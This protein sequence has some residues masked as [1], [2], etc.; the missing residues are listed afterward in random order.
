MRF[1][2]VKLVH[3]YDRSDR[4]SKNSDFTKRSDFYMIDNLSV[5]FHS[6]VIRILVVL[7]VDE[8]LLPNYVN[9]LLIS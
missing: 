8:I 7:S 5:A 4:H 3:P 1:V 2:R 6:F 9:W